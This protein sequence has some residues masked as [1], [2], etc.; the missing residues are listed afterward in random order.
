MTPHEE[1]A[2]MKLNHQEHAAH[3][4]ALRE[5]TQNH[6]ERLDRHSEHLTRLDESMGMLREALGGVATKN[7]I[8]D[9]RNDVSKQFNQN[10]RDAHNSVPAKLSVL[11]AGAMFLIA[12]IG[13]VINIHHG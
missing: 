9:L 8:M 2:Q 7:D 6:E 12:V 5:K 13:L 11:F 4:A 10:L 1:L 3:I